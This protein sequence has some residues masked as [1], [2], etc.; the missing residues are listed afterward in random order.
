MKKLS[1]LSS[2]ILASL[3]LLASCEQ[4]NTGV[5]PAAD[6]SIS[7]YSSIN[8]AA[9]RA[10]DTDFEDG[11]EISVSAYSGESLYGSNVK[12]SYASGLFTS[13]DAIVMPTD[14]SELAFW[15]VSILTVK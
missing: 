13:S 3:V 5:T 4:N 15:A 14:G 9:S 8:A 11:D 6:G 10:T 7:F 12:Y 2:G 1:T